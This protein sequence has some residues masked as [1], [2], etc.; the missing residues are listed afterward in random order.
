MTI[1]EFWQLIDKTRIESGNNP[2]QQAKLLEDALFELPVEEII[3]FEHLQS[4]LHAKAYLW[5]LWNVAYIIGE[6][7]GDDGFY[8]FRAWLIGQGQE[9]YET[10]IENPEILADYVSLDDRYEILSEALLYVA[11]TVYKRKTG[12]TGIFPCKRDETTVYP[13]LRKDT[14]CPDVEDEDCLKQ[15]YPKTWEKFG[16]E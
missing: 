5:D 7:C 8:D 2:A 6:G 11:A 1:D 15:R 10:A 9:V 16:W 14:G 4:Q 13:A 3:D 12:I